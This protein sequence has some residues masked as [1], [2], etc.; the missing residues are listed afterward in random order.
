MK[1][2]GA[3][4]Q[5]PTQTV[6]PAAIGRISLGSFL[7][8][9]ASVDPSGDL[10]GRNGPRRSINCR[11][12]DTCFARLLARLARCSLGDFRQHFNRDG[13][14]I[15]WGLC[16]MCTISENGRFFACGLWKGCGLGR[17]R[18]NFPPPLLRGRCRAKRGG[19]GLCGAAAPSVTPSLRCGVPPPPQQRGRKRITA[20]SDTCALRPAP[21]RF[22][23]CA[24]WR[25]SRRCRWFSGAPAR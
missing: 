8:A 21:A 9:F 23:G 13:S 22:S 3:S 25:A 6:Q 24:P 1:L 16:H 20:A 14:G 15:Q 5:S 4:L 2:D 7:E 10:F 17:W 18:N 12:G 19:G 11:H